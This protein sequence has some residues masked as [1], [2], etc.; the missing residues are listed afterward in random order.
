MMELR[1]AV[2]HDT[3][4][5]S[6]AKQRLG[7]LVL[8]AAALIAVTPTVQAGLILQPAAA[9]TD[10]GSL[11]ISVPDNTRDQSGLSLSERYVSL[12]EDFD[13]Y[14]AS[15][16]THDSAIA[17][18]T[19]RSPDDETGNFDFDLGGSYVIESFALWN[20]GG[21][22]PTNIIGFTLLADD[23]AAFD[24][25]VS[26]GSFT[27]NKN[28]GPAF[29]VLPEVFAFDPTAATFVRLTITSSNGVAAGFGEGAFE[30]Q[31][32]AVPEPSSLALLALGVAGLFA[33]RRNARARNKGDSSKYPPAKPEAPV[34]G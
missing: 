5:H 34:V 15:G 17:E 22:L 25:P 33:V 3:G 19:W 16:P 29:S 13:A 2:L 9:S 6:A 31:A 7:L 24:S 26:L 1:L 11:G 14:I 20:I 21:N 27:A 28:T 10:M 8:A 4:Q 23:D 32:L 12:E 18:T 30:V